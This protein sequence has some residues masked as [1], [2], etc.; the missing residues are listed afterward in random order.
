MSQSKEV[1][2]VVMIGLPGSGKSTFCQHYRQHLETESVNVIHVS[3]DEIIP[4]EKQA[5]MASRQDGKWKEER[6]NI[7]T[8][9]DQLIHQV[10]DDQTVLDS[11]LNEH[12]GK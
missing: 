9:V 8:A 4:L 10:K 2:I 1:C 6:E 7:V 3:Y 5:E 11:K 12:L